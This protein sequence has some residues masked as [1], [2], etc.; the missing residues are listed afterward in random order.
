M[1]FQLSN[2]Y[3]YKQKSVNLTFPILKW[4]VTF[5]AMGSPAK[6]IVAVQTSSA[7]AEKVFSCNEYSLS[8]LIL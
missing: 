8:L 5:A 4:L 2:G 1:D 3:S 6:S 7:A